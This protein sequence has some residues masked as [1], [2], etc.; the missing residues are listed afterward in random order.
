MMEERVT[1]LEHKI[2]QQ[3]EQLKKFADITADFIGLLREIRDE[4]KLSNKMQERISLLTSP[5]NT[6]VTARGTS[7]PRT[8]V[9]NSTMTPQPSI[10]TSASQ[11][12]PI[13]I[14]ALSPQ[15][16]PSPPPMT[17]TPPPSTTATPRAIL[18][19][20]FSPSLSVLGVVP[21]SAAAVSGVRV[22]DTLLSVGK[23][24]RPI[25]DALS[26]KNALLEN[27]IQRASG[28]TSSSLA[29]ALPC[30]FMRNGEL[31]HLLLGVESEVF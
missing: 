24:G 25:R 17:T 31:L 8:N 22:G 12:E 15:R 3:Q 5:P 23:H 2:Q 30:L 27:S 6:G 4:V 11:I 21:H 7:P 10:R 14:Q 1:A 29:E 20:F 13:A 26:L 18:G 19:M 9:G 28:G 16:R